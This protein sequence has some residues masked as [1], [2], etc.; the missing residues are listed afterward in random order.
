[1]L[2]QTQELAD[3]T[4]LVGE[5]DYEQNFVAWVDHYNDEPYYDVYRT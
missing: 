3:V 1:M 2:S 4:N 5:Q